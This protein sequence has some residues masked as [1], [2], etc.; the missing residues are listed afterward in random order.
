MDLPAYG[1][2]G[3]FPDRTIHIQQGFLKDFLKA[4]NIKQ[5]VLAGNS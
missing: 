5:C 2:T 4:L 1:L 3:P